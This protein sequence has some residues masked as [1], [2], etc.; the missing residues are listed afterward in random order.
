MSVYNGEKYLREAIDSILN[1]TFKDFEFIIVNDGS[2]D[3]SL[4]IIKSYND[5]RITIIN[6]KNTGLAKA[7]NEGIKIAKGKFI[8]RMDADDISEPERFKKEYKFM[9]VHDE[10][11]ALGTNA[12]IIDENGN[13]L[14]IT[15]LAFKNNM[16]EGEIII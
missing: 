8:A 11:V 2:T 1:Q 7:L 4:K 12:I 15:E 6:Q 3:N 16:S 14:Y 10:C 9:H 5:P 13:N